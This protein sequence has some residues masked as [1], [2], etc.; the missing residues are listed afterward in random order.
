[1]TPFLAQLSDAYLRCASNVLKYNAYRQ[2]RVTHSPS[3]RN[4]QLR[5]LVTGPIDGDKIFV[6]EHLL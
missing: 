2:T 1:M 5:T 3:C 4:L 6:R